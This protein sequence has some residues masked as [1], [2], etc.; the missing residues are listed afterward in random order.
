MLIRDGRSDFVKELVG[1]GYYDGCRTIDNEV[2]VEM[3]IHIEKMNGRA[4]L[5]VQRG[6]HRINGVTPLEY[7]YAIL[8]FQIKGVILD[9]VHGADSTR[10]KLGGGAIGS[11]DE[12]PFW[13]NE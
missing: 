9:D 7:L 3:F 12:T 8:P 5:T 4:Y 13:E 11:K 1:K 2:D 10:T 6:K